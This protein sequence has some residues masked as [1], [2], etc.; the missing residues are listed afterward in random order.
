MQGL[1]GSGRF[2]VWFWLGWSIIWAVQIPIAMATSLKTSIGY[3]IFISLMA[4]VLSCLGAMQSSLAMRKI[5]PADP[6]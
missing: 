5:D 1:L 6:L 3:L 4:L 2:W